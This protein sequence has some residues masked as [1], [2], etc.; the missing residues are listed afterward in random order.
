VTPVF[1]GK[2]NFDP[3]VKPEDLVTNKFLDPSIGFAK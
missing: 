3:A 2:A 1:K